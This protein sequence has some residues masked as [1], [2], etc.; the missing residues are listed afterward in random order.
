MSG[1]VLNQACGRNGWNRRGFVR[2]GTSAVLVGVLLTA[3]VAWQSVPVF[4]AGL[5]MSLLA[6]YL[7][8]FGASAVMALLAA[9]IV[10]RTRRRQIF[11][12]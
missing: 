3:S 11:M 9:L 12:R 1:L 4:V 6:A 5:G 7:S 2:V 10:G 8:N